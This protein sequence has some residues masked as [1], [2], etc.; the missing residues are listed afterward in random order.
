MIRDLITGING[1]IGQN[2]TKIIK[3]KSLWFSGVGRTVRIVEGTY[4]KLDI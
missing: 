1:F 4:F 3:R 2:L